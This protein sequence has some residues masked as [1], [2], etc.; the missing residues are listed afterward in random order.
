MNKI[1]M[2][3]LGFRPDFNWETRFNLKTELNGYLV[4]TVDLGIDHNFLGDKPLYYETMIFNHNSDEEV[5]Y[6]CR[7]STE[8]EARQGHLDAI[9]YVKEKLINYYGN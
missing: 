3:R 7:Y 5:G 1:D 6:Q 9:Q 8:E 2:S 4:S